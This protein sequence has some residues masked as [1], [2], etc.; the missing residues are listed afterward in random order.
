MAT[1]SKSSFWRLA[2][3]AAGILVGLKLAGYVDWPWLGVTAP[4]WVPLTISVGVR[5]A[6]LV[7]LLVAVWWID[8]GGVASELTMVAHEVAGW[9][10]F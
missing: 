3:V 2:I 10:S 7:A 4:L 6:L 9:I 5:L 1:G 8:P